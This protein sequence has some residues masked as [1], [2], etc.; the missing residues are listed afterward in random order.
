MNKIK[1]YV[2]LALLGGLLVIL[3][4]TLFVLL[5][6]WLLQSLGSLIAPVSDPLK[7]LFGWP[8]LT[9]DVLVVSLFLV[10][11]ILIG[12]LVRT[13]IG[14]WLHK[15]VDQ[16]LVRLAPGY[17][18]IRAMVRQLLGGDGTGPLSG[19][20]VLA[21]I[22]GKN[23]STSVTGI[24]TSKHKSGLVTVYVPTAPVPTSGLTYHLPADAVQYLPEVTV[25]EAMRTI[26]ACGAGTADMLGS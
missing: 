11:C 7:E 19:E 16:L 12:I 25:E 3:P 4:V 2:G 20:V 23:C 17:K 15:V 6:R 22:Y 18:T 5:G 1:S 9:S 24:V 26:I 10:I 21:Q 8:A 14:R 13:A